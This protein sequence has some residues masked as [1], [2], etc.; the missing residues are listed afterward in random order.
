[1]L[2]A[3]IRAERENQTSEK[4]ATKSPRKS[5]KSKQTEFGWQNADNSPTAE[6]AKPEHSA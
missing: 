4:K 6:Q 5:K 1:V 3:R 2:L